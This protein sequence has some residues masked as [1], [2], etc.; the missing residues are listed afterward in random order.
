MMKTINAALASFGMSGEIFHAPLLSAHKGFNLISILERTKNRSHDR[1]PSANIV[2]SYEEILKND[3]VDLV[4]VN[5]PDK[6]HYEMAMEA[7]KADKH[8]I[9]EKPFTLSVKEADELISLSRKTGKLLSVFQNR[10]WEGDFQTVK[11]IIDEGLL[12][13]LVEYEAHFDR[14][15][16]YLQKGSWKEQVE[17]NTGSIY[18]L[19]SHLIDQ[20]LFLFGLPEAVFADIRALRTGAE[21]DDSFTL[22]MRYPEIKVSLKVS[23]LVREPGPR[24]LLHGTDGSFLKWGIDPQE[25]AMKAGRQP[26]SPGWGEEPEE[27]WGILNTD[28]NGKHYRSKY[29]TLPGNYLAYYDDIYDSITNHHEPSVTAEQGRDV[30][31]VIEAAK[32]SSLSRSEVGI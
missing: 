14:Y 27:F 9:V 2:R 29:E 6:F 15:R 11:K 31:R 30:I 32:K 18:N 7:I 4:I 23:Y 3:K 28:L 16:N 20:V 25:E 22:L 13:R 21:V 5:T 19:G 10:R 24:F 26:G 1:Y 8:V 12:G 17:S